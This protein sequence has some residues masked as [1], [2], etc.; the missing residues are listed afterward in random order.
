MV[1]LHIL[2]FSGEEP[3]LRKRG[4]SWPRLQRQVESRQVCDTC[5]QILSPVVFSPKHNECHCFSMIRSSQ[6]K[7]F[8]CWN[9]C[10]RVQKQSK[11]VLWRSGPRSR[12]GRTD[13]QAP[14]V[15]SGWSSDVPLW[16]TTP[17]PHQGQPS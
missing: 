10:Q 2:Y 5:L 14:V 8:K 6:L 7:G 4:L 3:E 13:Q 9:M 17:C 16:V 11:C 1:L 12:E 15:V